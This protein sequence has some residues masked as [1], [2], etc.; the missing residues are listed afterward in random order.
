MYRI[1]A[2]ALLSVA[3]VGVLAQQAPKPPAPAPVTPQQE[4]QKDQARIAELRQMIALQEQQARGEYDLMQRAEGQ[5]KQHYTN[6][7]ALDAGIAH[8]RAQIALLL[9]DEKLMRAET[10]CHEANISW[11]TW[12]QYLQVAITTS[13]DAQ[14]YSKI[15]REDQE[16]ANEAKDD[17]AAAQF[18]MGR[19]KIDADLAAG[20]KTRADAEQQRATAEER[21][22]QG[23]VEAANKLV[24]NSCKITLPVAQSHNVPLPPVT[25]K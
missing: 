7:L 22:A 8:R 11:R 10:T 15:A 19:A 5:A 3:A 12:Q 21:K 1:V 24:A 2:S 18:L 16:A 25:R 17:P 9:K 20:L 6:Y 4:T 14:H 13:E 23:Q